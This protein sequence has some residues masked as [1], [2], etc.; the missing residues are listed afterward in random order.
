MKSAL[1]GNCDGLVNLG[2][3][4]GMGEGVEKYLVEAYKFFGV[5]AEL[6]DKQAASMLPLIKEKMTPGQFAL[7]QKDIA[8]L[9]QEIKK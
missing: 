3:C 6:G 8:S 5:A 1:Q 9:L 4:Y 7:A 2:K